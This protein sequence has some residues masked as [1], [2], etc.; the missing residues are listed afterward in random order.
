MVD[1]FY[2]YF[3]WRTLVIPSKA[4]VELSLRDDSLKTSAQ[5]RLEAIRALFSTEIY[6]MNIIFVYL[7]TQAVIRFVCYS[8]IRFSSQQ[9]FTDW[10]PIKDEYFFIIYLTELWI[11][12][13]LF[14]FLFD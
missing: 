8:W 6:K 12:I 13:G 11:T 14:A 2:T 1:G 10:I 7:Q 5:K 9:A 3:K 4:A